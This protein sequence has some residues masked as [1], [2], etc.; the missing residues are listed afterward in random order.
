MRMLSNVPLGMLW[1][2]LPQSLRKFGR[3]AGLIQTSKCSSWFS[4]V[5]MLPPP[6]KAV[7]VWKFW[8]SSAAYLWALSWDQDMPVS[9]MSSKAPFAVTWAIVKVEQKRLIFFW[10]KVKYGVENSKM[11]ISSTELRYPWQPSDKLPSRFTPNQVINYKGEFG[12]DLQRQTAT[13]T[14]LFNSD[15]AAKAAFCQDLNLSRTVLSQI[16]SVLLQWIAGLILSGS[17]Q[18]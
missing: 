14:G 8:L 3:A 18:L 2:I 15:W 17:L 4:V 6:R 13:L 1:L 11:G 16:R 7:I 12:I 10:V 5:L 9:S